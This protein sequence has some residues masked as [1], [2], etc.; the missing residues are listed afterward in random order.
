MKLHLTVY[1]V[2]TSL[3]G[4]SLLI[5]VL[6][7]TSSI[8]STQ[9]PSSVPNGKMY[10][11]KYLGGSF[12]L[13]GESRKMS[14]LELGWRVGLYYLEESRLASTR[15]GLRL[16]ETVKVDHESLMFWPS[17]RDDEFFIGG[18]P[19]KKVRDPMDRL[20]HHCIATT[21][22]GRKEST[23]KITALDHFFLRC[24]YAKGVTCNIPYWLARY[25]NGVRDKDLT[26]GDTL[27]VEPRAHVFKKKSLIT[28]KALLDLGGGVCCWPA[29]LQVREGDEVEE[30]TNKKAGGS[31]EMYR[32]MSMGGW[33]YLSTRDNLDPHL[34]IDPFLGHETNYPPYGYTGHMPP[35]YEY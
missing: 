32:G 25:L 24:I 27:S 28:M 1:T 22:S 2:R 15:S 11:P 12:R 30:A 35:G 17:I 3:T 5:L 6:L 26:Y 14:L 18:T 13:G 21:I 9:M 8:A 33:Q 19:V 29:T 23:H 10:D 20:A 31:A 4:T 7:V 16:G 34:Q